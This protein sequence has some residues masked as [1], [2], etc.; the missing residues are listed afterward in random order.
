MTCLYQLSPPP[1]ETE[2]VARDL[3]SLAQDRG[4]NSLG[5]GT[6]MNPFLAQQQT[7]TV[8]AVSG[9]VDREDCSTTA[10][11]PTDFTP[12]PHTSSG[13]GNNLNNG[14]EPRNDVEAPASQYETDGNAMHEFLQ[15]IMSGGDGFPNLSAPGN[16]SVTWTPR[17]VFDFGQ[18]TSLELN[19]VDLNFLDDYNQHNPFAP[20]VETPETAISLRGSSTGD[21]PSALG[22]ESL[23]KTST[24]RFRPVSQDT[25]A[26]DQQNLSLPVAATN[27]KLRIERRVLSETLSFNMRDRV[28]AL[29]ISTC[30]EGN[31]PRT[32]LSFPSLDLLDSLLQFYL[33]SK[34][35]MSSQYI[36]VPTLSLSRTRPELIAAMAAAGATLAPDASLRKLG[37]AIMEALRTSVP[38]LI[39]ADVSTLAR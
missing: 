9:D 26:S 38:Q 15:T 21:P 3:L 11:P 39:E 32:V 31:V 8:F 24:W 37:Y 33:T 18:N 29:I 30:K 1:P 25:G 7:P 34:A 28:L 19:D 16:I 23:Q 22:A 10:H 17:D 27:T 13:L 6:A 35:A 4:R 14:Y 20:Y 2:A 36:H 5:E 12:D